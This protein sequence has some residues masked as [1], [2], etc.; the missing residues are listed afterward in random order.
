MQTSS[1]TMTDFVRQKRRSLT[2]VCHESLEHYIRPGQLVIDATLGNGHDTE[3]LAR[4][5]GADGH[6]YGF[7]IQSDAIKKTRERLLENNLLERCTLHHE[8][9]DKMLQLLPQE[10]RKKI[11][12]IMFNLGYL[13]GSDKSCVTTSPSTLAALSRSLDILEDSGVLSIMAYPGHE[14]GKVETAAVERW[15]QSLDRNRYR[16]ET[17]RSTGTGPVLFII[18]SLRR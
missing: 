16:I 10:T 8:S 9:H 13:P 18:Q 5:V 12:A 4:L 7:D 15:A 3:F 11:S 2:I 14:E 1:V 6:V 17:R